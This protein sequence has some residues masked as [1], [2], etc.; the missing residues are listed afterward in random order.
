VNDAVLSPQGETIGI[1]SGTHG[2]G[3]S[4]KITTGIG[5]IKLAPA[6]GERPWGARG[7]RSASAS[8]P[9]VLAPWDPADEQPGRLLP[10]PYLPV[11]STG[12]VRDALSALLG[13]EW[14]EPVAVV[15]IRP[16]SAL[17]FC[18]RL[19]GRR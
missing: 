15:D 1:E 10:S 7:A 16:E 11:M 19:T 14:S 2:H 13:K 18:A 5:A 3:R 9:R 12:D 4:R 6:Q 17:A 8:A